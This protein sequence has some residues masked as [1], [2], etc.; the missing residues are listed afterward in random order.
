MKKQTMIKMMVAVGVISFL[1]LPNARA[2]TAVNAYA[3]N[4]DSSTGPAGYPTV[5]TANFTTVNDVLLGL[6]PTVVGDPTG[7]GYATRGSVTDGSL[8]TIPNGGSD[9]SM[10]QAVNTGGLNGITSLTY[11]LTSATQLSSIQYYGG[12]V[13]GGR[14]NINFTV[15]YSTDNGATYT[16]LIDPTGDSYFFNSPSGDATG[17]MNDG[18]TTTFDRRL[19]G[20]GPVSNFVNVTDTAGNLGGNALITDLQF[21]FGASPFLAAGWNGLEQLTAIAAAPVPEPGVYA[22]FGAGLLLLMAFRKR[23]AA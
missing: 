14:P 2:T 7:G 3:D 17:G 11:I 6:T 22:L 18:N 23:K 10:F 5:W 8:T 4:G 9:Y 20:T 1:T 12:W 21:S 15:S 19:G 13:D 16:S